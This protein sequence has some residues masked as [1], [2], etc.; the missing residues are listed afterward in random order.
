ELA[1]D[2]TPAANLTTFASAVADSGQ[3]DSASAARAD[4]VPAYTAPADV[5]AMADVEAMAAA[6]EL[7]LGRDLLRTWLLF[8]RAGLRVDVH[9]EIKDCPETHASLR[10]LLGRQNSSGS[11][12]LPDGSARFTRPT[13][14]FSVGRSTT[15]VPRSHRRSDA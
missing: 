1:D 2:G 9:S 11:E 5:A 13:A 14:A 8:D 3:A 4:T 15:R 6:R 7:R 12:T 10:D